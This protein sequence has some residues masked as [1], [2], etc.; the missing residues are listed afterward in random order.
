MAPS[1]RVTRSTASTLPK[2][3]LNLG[4]DKMMK[5][6]K[7]LDQDEAVSEEEAESTEEKELGQEEEGEASD[8]DE[9]TVHKDDKGAESRKKK[10]PGNN[11]ALASSLTHILGKTLKSKGA[12]SA[13]ILA[14]SGVEKR[15]FEEKLEGKAKKMLR[16]EKKREMDVDRVK[17]QPEG[18]DYER[19]LKKVATRGVV[20]LF[21]A[22]RTQQ[23]T[24]VEVGKIGSVAKSESVHREAAKMDKAN[25]LSLLKGN[26]AT[27]ETT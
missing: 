7:E 13:P 24:S 1:T 3:T 22:I 15:L 12:Q 8:S 19:K 16:Q 18:M 25:F 5:D 23:Q 10:D 20:Q 27:T 26:D 21:N 14:R 2:G 11:L 9:D 17:P 4:Q 6:K